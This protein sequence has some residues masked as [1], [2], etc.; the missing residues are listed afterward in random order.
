MKYSYCVLP[1]PK[2]DAIAA[3]IALDEIFL[4]MFSSLLFFSL[5][6]TR[7]CFQEENFQVSVFY[8]SILS[9]VRII[10]EKFFPTR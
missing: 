5:I 6:L 10:L 4:I 1:G 9:T 3:D 8:I 2:S 7:R